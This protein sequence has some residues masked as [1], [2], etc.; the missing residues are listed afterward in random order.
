MCS[1]QTRGIVEILKAL[2]VAFRK[3][4]RLVFVIYF[5]IRFAIRRHLYAPDWCSQQRNHRIL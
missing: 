3:T 2:D 4:Y 5:M 1:S